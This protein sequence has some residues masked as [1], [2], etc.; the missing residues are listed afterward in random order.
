MERE[1]RRQGS[2]LGDRPDEFHGLPAAGA[3]GWG[4]GI[5]QHAA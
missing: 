5:G 3:K 4:G 1:Q 2:Q